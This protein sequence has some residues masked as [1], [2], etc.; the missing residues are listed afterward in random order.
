MSTDRRSPNWPQLG[1]DR[2]GTV[3]RSGR[4]LLFGLGTGLISLFGAPVL[5]QSDSGRRWAA[6][7]R[8]RADRL[9]GLSPGVEPGPAPGTRRALLWLAVQATAGLALG[10]FGLLVVGNAVVA[11]LAM[12]FW[13]VFSRS[14]PPRLFV[15]IPVTNWRTALL[16]G[17]VQL[18]LLI[19]VAAVAFP[20]L[21]RAHARCCQVI[22]S[23][24]EADRLTERVTVL[25]ES[26]AD[27]L[28]AHG[29]ELRRIERDLHD[30][31]Q[32]RLV[33]VAVRLGVAEQAHEQGDHELVG[34]LLRQAHEGT[35]T[36]MTELRAVLRSVYP[37]ILSDRGLTG[38]LTALAADSAVPVR[39]IAEGLGR[40]PA[41]VEAVV[42]FVVAEALTNVSR[43]SRATS[44]EV[45]VG[46]DEGHLIASV[47]DDGAGGADP[48]LG[49]GLSG[50]RN[51][52]RALDGTFTVA[53]PVGGPTT[54]RVELPCAW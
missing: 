34:R 20:V 44:A 6:G 4:Y 39:L 5:I 43:H 7:H 22:L 47:S 51:R 54:I 40:L 16:L 12:G 38:A 25:T 23:R 45:W 10:V 29:A 3:L 52:V 32:A 48:G 19:L 13:W 26:R 28:D 49:T 30:G 24:S 1:R 15:D 50:I 9:L 21:A 27:V 42:Y 37:P 17:P 33:A 14:D 36:A 41:T 18:V 53:S 2:A 31:T 35:E 11:G 46:I 8:R